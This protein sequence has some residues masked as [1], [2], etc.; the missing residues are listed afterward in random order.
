MRKLIGQLAFIN[1]FAGL[2]VGGCGP[3]ERNVIIDRAP[4]L[5]VEVPFNPGKVDAIVDEVKEFS[6]EQHMEFLVAR[7]T[8]W[9]SQFN[10]SADA[11]RLNL[12]VIHSEMDQGVFIV[13]ATARGAPSPADRRLAQEFLDRVR[14]SGGA[15]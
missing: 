3:S 8:A 9:Q 12:K 15:Q 2:T 11:Y 5:K 4:F 6:K 10:A 1:A 13:A 7:E 14:R